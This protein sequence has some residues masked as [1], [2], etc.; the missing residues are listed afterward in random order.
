MCAVI[1]KPLSEGHRAA[2]HLEGSSGGTTADA[3]FGR[4][5][6]F[7]GAV[8]LAPAALIQVKDVL[9]SS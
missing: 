4:R 1:S 2:M 3:A 7:Q 5:P 8:V 9:R 6:F